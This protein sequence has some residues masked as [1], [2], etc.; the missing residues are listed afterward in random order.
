MTWKR[1]R[2]DIKSI[3]TG[4]RTFGDKLSNAFSLRVVNEFSREFNGALGHRRKRP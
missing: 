3:N 2:Y 1:H 4:G